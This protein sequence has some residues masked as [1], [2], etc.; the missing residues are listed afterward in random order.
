MLFID[1]GLDR[2]EDVY[3]ALHAER[4]LLVQSDSVVL[5]HNRDLYPEVVVDKL[6]YN[7]LL[8]AALLMRE[9]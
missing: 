3:R 8:N 2:T 1:E 4:L 9:Q 6:G 5:H 7:Q